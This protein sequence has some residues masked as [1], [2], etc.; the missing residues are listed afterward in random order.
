ML[1]N[2]DKKEVND[3]IKNSSI[4]YLS[5][6]IYNA[7]S[8]N[9]KQTFRLPSHLSNAITD[10]GASGNYAPETALPYMVNVIAHTDDPNAAPI[11]G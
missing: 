8:K 10:T 11:S 1:Y 6:K 7:T 3:N 2:N 4:Y 9:T 5:N